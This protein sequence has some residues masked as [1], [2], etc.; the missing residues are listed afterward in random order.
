MITK[1]GSRADKRT[2]NNTAEDEEEVVESSNLPQA[3][4][5]GSGLVVKIHTSS[6]SEHYYRARKSHS[7]INS[8]TCITDTQRKAYRVDL[9]K[10][11]FL[12]KYLY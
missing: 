7:S 5:W 1:G 11:M 2:T 9:H 6:K 12:S 8:M 3:I 10:A 4:D